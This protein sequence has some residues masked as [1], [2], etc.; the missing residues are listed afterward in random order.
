MGTL[1]FIIYYTTILW[2]KPKWEWRKCIFSDM[3]KPNFWYFCKI[4]LKNPHSFEPFYFPKSFYYKFKTVPNRLLVALKEIVEVLVLDKFSYLWTNENNFFNFASLSLVNFSR[5]CVKA[6]SS[7]FIVFTEFF[8]RTCFKCMDGN[9]IL[10]SFT[11]G[12]F[13]TFMIP[14]SR[15]FL[16]GQSFLE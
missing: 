5:K 1:V 11:S 16:A 2:E 12:W 4:C 7:W 15:D 9:K 6:V 8:I 10:L 3:L 14:G 13:S